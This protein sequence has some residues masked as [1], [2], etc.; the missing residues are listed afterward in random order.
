M[1]VLSRNEKSLRESGCILTEILYRAHQTTDPA[2]KF[3][4]LWFVVDQ[5]LWEL[6]WRPIR[7]VKVYYGKNEVKIEAERVPEMILAQCHTVSQIDFCIRIICI[8]VSTSV[9]TL[10]FVEI[11][12]YRPY[13]CNS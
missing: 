6:G 7:P 8:S 11:F 2:A 13:R 9:S 1:R 3:L 5:I 12:F 4:P 10:F